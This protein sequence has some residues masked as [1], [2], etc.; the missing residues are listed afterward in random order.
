MPKGALNALLLV[1]NRSLFVRLLQFVNNSN[2]AFL[3]KHINKI[4]D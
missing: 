3:P 4:P 2:M 1:V